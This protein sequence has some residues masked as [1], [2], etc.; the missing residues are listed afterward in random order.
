MR[1]EVDL[2]KNEESEV[3]TEC[4]DQEVL[5]KRVES[6]RHSRGRNHHGRESGVKT[7]SH[8]RRHPHKNINEQENQSVCRLLGDSRLLCSPVTTH[9]L[10]VS[11]RPVSGPKRLKS[12]HPS[13]CQPV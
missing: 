13:D 11:P 9:N 1:R 12:G 2:W 6:G 10:S 8:G 3:R 4:T 7:V 5:R